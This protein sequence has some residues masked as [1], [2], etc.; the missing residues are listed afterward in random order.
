[1]LVLP[2]V[3]LSPVVFLPGGRPAD[4]KNTDTLLRCHS[5]VLTRQ[6]CSGQQ[7]RPDSTFSW[8]DCWCR[9][10]VARD[11]T[12]YYYVRRSSCILSLLKESEMPLP[13]HSWDYDYYNIVL[14]Y[15]NLNKSYQ[16]EK[17]RLASACCLRLKAIKLIYSIHLGMIFFKRHQL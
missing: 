13:S 16:D 8:A 4:A 6:I 10:W 12:I 1:M 7:P 3:L 15:R 14:P 17:S 9:V 11:G 2:R 5:L